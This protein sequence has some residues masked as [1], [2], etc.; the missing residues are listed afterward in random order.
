MI[1]I[2]KD[3]PIKQPA[4][5]RNAQIYPFSKMAVGDSFVLPENMRRKVAPCASKYQLRHPG[6]QF[7]IGKQGDGTIR[8]WRTT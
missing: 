5:G 7:S 6:V 3:V 2:E 4:T 1:S 8:I